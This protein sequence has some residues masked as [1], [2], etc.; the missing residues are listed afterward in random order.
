MYKTV[1][2]II[3]LILLLSVTPLFAQEDSIV[4]VGVPLSVTYQMPLDNLERVQNLSS[5][6]EFL[7][8]ANLNLGLQLFFRLGEAVSLGIESGV[9][10]SASE[11]KSKVVSAVKQIQNEINDS[12]HNGTLGDSMPFTIDVP[13]RA[14]IAVSLADAIDIDLYGG[15][16]FTDLIKQKKELMFD[17]GTRIGFSTGSGTL[18]AE[19]AY[20]FPGSYSLSSITNGFSNY[21]DNALK[22]GLGYRFG[23]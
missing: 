23:R 1:I 6:E 20:V 9:S 16:Y 22:V 18:F 15:A 5:F 8:D 12:E 17:I 21:W 19:V 11:I 13:L 2:A 4:W 10:L 7:M 3:S 14:V